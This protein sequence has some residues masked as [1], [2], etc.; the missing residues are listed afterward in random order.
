[1]T[2][3]IRNKLISPV[4]QLLHCAI[5]V[6]SVMRDVLVSDLRSLCS[7]CLFWFSSSTQIHDAVNYAVPS[8][9][10]PEHHEGTVSLAVAILRHLCGW[11]ILRLCEDRRTGFG[12][13][14]Q[15]VSS[16]I[17]ANNFLCCRFFLI[18]D[19]ADWRNGWPWDEIARTIAAL[20][21]EISTNFIIFLLIYHES[22][23]ISANYNFQ[24]LISRLPNVIM[25]L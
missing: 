12:G 2:V 20:Q 4:L 1:M 6:F 13:G 14:C 18:I 10:P 8:W 22:V 5:A 9:G 25:G 3:L 11:R 15:I 16:W 19:G 23:K 17:V 24:L 7:T 21:G